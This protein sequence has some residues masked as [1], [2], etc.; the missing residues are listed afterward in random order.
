VRLVPPLLNGRLVR[1]RT[2]FEAERIAA[3]EFQLREHVGKLLNA[4]CRETFRDAVAPAVFIGGFGVATPRVTIQAFE[5]FLSAL[6]EA[7]PASENQF[8]MAAFGDTGAT[9]EART[10]SMVAE[11]IVALGAAGGRF[12]A[13]FG[14]APYTPFFPCAHHAGG[15]EGVSI[16]MSGPA[17]LR[18]AIRHRGAR[19]LDDVIARAQAE[20]LTVAASLATRMAHELG[21]EFLGCDPSQAPLFDLD[22]SGANSIGAAI[23][24]CSGVP[25]GTPGTKA[26]FYRLMAAL[27]KGNI[28]AGVPLCGF[29]NGSFLP[30]SEDDRIAA[31]VAEGRLTYSGILS[32]CHVCAAGLD[33]VVVEPGTRPSTVAG[34]LRDVAVTHLLKGRALAARLIVPTPDMAT[35]DRGYYILGGLLGRAPVMMLDPESP[36]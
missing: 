4:Y 24:D 28:A 18:Q 36:L 3:E 31:R 33:M 26:G 10:F 34:I 7:L 19:S 30:V 22:S 20:T 32:L 2:R 8:A 14:S 17:A 16:G 35:D 11:A 1:A 5:G 23:E 25:L 15:I 6:V 27:Q 29:L 12:G 9:A 21:T 13:M